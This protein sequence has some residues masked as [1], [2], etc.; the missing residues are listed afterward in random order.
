MKLV[1]YFALLVLL[2][3]WSS[4]ASTLQYVQPDYYLGQLVRGILAVASHAGQPQYQVIQDAEA[5]RKAQAALNR[6][7][8]HP[9]TSYTYN[10]INIVLIRGMDNEPNGFSFGNNIFI[11]KSMVNT[12]SDRQL[13]AVVAHELAH[14]EKA[15]NLQKTVMP[16]GA[17]TYQLKN[18]YES[19]K[20]GQWPRGKDLVQS[21]QELMETGGLALELQA[22]CVAARQLE[23]M[24]SLG[25]PHSA[26]DLN[27]AT[28]TILGF[29]ITKDA[30][31]DDPSAIRAQALKNKTYEYGCSIF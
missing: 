8:A 13:T 28:S 31:S 12:L 7:Y 1:K 2:M 11:T 17:V 26:E 20:S 15:H 21:I 18:I 30:I 14:S 16:L 29:D 9:A 5:Q 19:V 24:K 6:I 3:P 27:D 23:H 22:D 25:L 4:Y 10:K